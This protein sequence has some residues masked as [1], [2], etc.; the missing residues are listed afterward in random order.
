MIMWKVIAKTS[1]SLKNTVKN[2]GLTALT[3]SKI[4]KNFGFSTAIA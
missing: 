3:V 1:V 2:N 4:V